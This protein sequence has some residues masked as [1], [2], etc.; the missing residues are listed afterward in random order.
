MRVLGNGHF[1]NVCAGPLSCY[2]WTSNSKPEQASHL[3]WQLE[4]R[5]LSV[6]TSTSTE[7]PAFALNVMHFQ[8]D[9]L[10]QITVHGTYSFRKLLSSSP[11]TRSQ[12]ICWSVI[13]TKALNKRTETL[14]D[15]QFFFNSDKC[16]INITC[17]SIFVK[18]TA[19]GIYVYSRRRSW[20][21]TPLGPNFPWPVGTP[22]FP[23]K[24]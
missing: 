17:T 24:G 9:I 7:N 2:Y 21:Q 4:G 16:Q 1:Q 14:V 20:V 6:T 22:K 18:L 12:Y 23:L 11:A 3:S 15:N 5:N 8:L 10:G 19:W 13:F